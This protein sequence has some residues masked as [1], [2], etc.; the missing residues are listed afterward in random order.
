M[1]NK[2]DANQLRQWAFDH[3][4]EEPIEY[5]DLLAQFEAEGHRDAAVHLRTL[6]HAGLIEMK[7]GINADGSR[8]HRVNKVAG[9]TL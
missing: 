6:K 7:A 8:F 1:A 3:V 4:P 9:A 5:S 2:L